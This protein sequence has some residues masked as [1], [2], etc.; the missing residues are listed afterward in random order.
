MKSTSVRTRHLIDW[1]LDISREKPE[2]FR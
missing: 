2:F 1:L